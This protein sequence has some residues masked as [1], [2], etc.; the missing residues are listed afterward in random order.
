MK[1]ISS[2]FKMK[3]CEMNK[4]IMGFKKLTGIVIGMIVISAALMANEPSGYTQEGIGLVKQVWKDMKSSNTQALE[5]I[6]GEGFQSAHEDG[7]VRDKK[8]ELKLIKGLKLEGYILENFKVSKENSVL[9]I[10]YTVEV[11]E[12]IDKESLTRK[13][14]LRMS[15]FLKTKEGWKWIAHNNFKPIK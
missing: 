4:S 1:N 14:A 15:I 11:K 12:T 13:P 2:N 9:I 6:M 7:I 3:E 5:K 8:E 10:S